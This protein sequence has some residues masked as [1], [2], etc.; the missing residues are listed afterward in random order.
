M[1]IK[2][3][4]SQKYT[5]WHDPHEFSMRITAKC[6]IFLATHLILNLN[7]EYKSNIIAF[8]K[9]I[10]LAK[11]NQPKMQGRTSCVTP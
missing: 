11:K 7:E 10:L 8:Y 3:G 2:D 5:T 6:G 9:V 1:Q 4:G